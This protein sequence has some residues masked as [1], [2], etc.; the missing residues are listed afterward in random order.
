MGVGATHIDHVVV[1]SNHSEKTARLFSETYGIEIKR[2]MSRPGTG[3]HMEFA[4]LDEVVLEWVDSPDFDALLL[5]LNYNFKTEGYLEVGRAIE[6]YDLFVD[7]RHCVAQFSRRHVAASQPAQCGL[8]DHQRVADL[9]GHDRREP[10][11]RREPLALRRLALEA[12]NRIGQRIE[13]R[14]EQ[15]GVLVFPACG[16]A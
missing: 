2:T 14:S 11:E 12:G 4:K 16:G 3:A 5:D 15:L 8:D 13:S 6:P 10:A 7:V 9:V 1:G